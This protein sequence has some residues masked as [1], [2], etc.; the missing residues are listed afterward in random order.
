MYFL[1]RKWAPKYPFLHERTLAY[2]SPTI[3][4]HL[5][6]IT[7]NC[8]QLKNRFWYY[9]G[10]SPMFTHFVHLQIQIS[11]VL[12]K[13]KQS[14][15]SQLYKCQ[16]NLKSCFWHKKTCRGNFIAHTMEIII[17]R[18]GGFHH[19]KIKITAYEL[20]VAYGLIR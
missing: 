6:L 2:N 4:H 12:C 11:K 15:Q 14:H 5:Y 16:D 1:N 3:E 20:N 13:I 17:K 10:H 8:Q 18:N 19:M 7:W 9:H